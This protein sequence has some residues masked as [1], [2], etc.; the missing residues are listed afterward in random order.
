VEGAV[1]L[2]VKTTMTTM[3]TIRVTPPPQAMPMMAPVDNMG[4]DGGDPLPPAG[5]GIGGGVTA[6]VAVA[7]GGPVMPYVERK[8]EGNVAADEVIRRVAIVEICE[9]GRREEFIICGN[10]M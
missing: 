2:T 6:V 7:V 10:Q 8:E 3:M 1:F 5:G 4:V 9:M